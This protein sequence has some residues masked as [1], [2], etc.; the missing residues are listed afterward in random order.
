MFS[1]SAKADRPYGLSAFAKRLLFIRLE[2][3]AGGILAAA[4]I[5]GPHADLGGVAG[6]LI[7]MISA[8]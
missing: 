4:G 1:A 7:R 2:S 8:V 3:R 6:V 5:V